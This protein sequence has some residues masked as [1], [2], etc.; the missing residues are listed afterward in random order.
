MSAD[1]T[2]GIVKLRVHDQITFGFDLL[3]RNDLA[4]HNNANVIDDLAEIMV[5]TRSK[6]RS[7]SASINNNAISK[8]SNLN[9]HIIFKSTD[10]T[11]KVVDVDKVDNK[12]N[13]LS[14]LDCAG[15]KLL[16]V[17]KHSTDG[18]LIVRHW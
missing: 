16:N 3:Y 15:Y 12:D 11:S 8:Q 6:T 7:Q 9:K 17:D 13:V 1:L 5:I 2:S 10:N 4:I 18:R 14:T